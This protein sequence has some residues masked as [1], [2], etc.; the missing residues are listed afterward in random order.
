MNSR[1]AAMLDLG[2]GL[3]FN[4]GDHDLH[5]LRTRGIENEEREFAVARDQADTVIFS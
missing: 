5:A 3:F 4:G 2:R 1:S